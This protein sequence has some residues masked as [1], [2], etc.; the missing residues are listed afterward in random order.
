MNFPYQ[1]LL[2]RDVL[3]MKE[4]V[5]ALSNTISHATKFIL[6]IK[7]G[8][9]NSSL[10]ESAV[11]EINKQRSSLANALLEMQQRM[12]D[13]RL[14]EERRRW[15]V[16]GLA[17]FVD[18]LRNDSNDTSNLYNTI[19]REIIK[20]VGANQGNLFIVNEEEG[21]GKCLELAACY[22]FDRRKFLSKKIAV[23]EGLVG[24]VYL[25]GESSYLTNIPADY[26]YITSGLGL[27]TPRCL[28]IVPLKVNEQI[29]GVLELASFEKLELYR[30]EFI[31]KLGESI[32]ATIFNAKIN[33]RN[34]SLLKLSQ[35]QTSVLMAQEEEMRQN[36]EELGATQEEM[37]RVSSEMEGQLLAINKTMA[38][39]EFNLN[40]EIIVANNNFLNLMEYSM[41]ELEGSHHRIFVNSQE[42][43]SEEYIKFW[44]ELSGGESKT[45]EFKRITK[46]GKEVFIKGIYTPIFDQTGRPKK[47][48]KIAYE[49]TESKELEQQIKNQLEETQAQEEEL[50][51]N[52]E[53]LM[54]TQEEVQRQLRESE[55]L[56]R[57][58]SA[59]EKVFNLTTILSEADVF[60]TITYV[61]DKLC[62]VSGYSREELI[63][64]PHNIFRDPEMPKALF[65]LM[66][67]TIKQGEP[68]RGIIKNRAK[69]GTHYWVDA[70]ISPVFDENGKPVKY[71]GAR[72]VIPDDNM[73]EKLY[74]DMLNGLQPEGKI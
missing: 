65:K 29:S 54:A 16:E 34:Q 44:E 9:L 23:G 57:E 50:R 61:N 69:D 58:A 56:Q 11:A 33:E 59:R 41:A 49:I 53:E 1:F 64:K 30:Q 21:Q 73:A 13:I 6:D 36:M 47:I 17:K 45:G 62:E 67:S 14:E 70:V 35:E 24:Q 20:Y 38:T 46:S 39:I 10:Q 48:L 52:L 5:G 25:E 27:A 7:E 37:A 19:L 42:R 74:Q 63:G 2:K 22:A 32:A 66:W 18:I 12:K 60:G 26:V 28:Y 3:K 68:F 8:N 4:E 40:G 72:Y 15:S 55:R 71:I 31:E 43:Q 51:Q